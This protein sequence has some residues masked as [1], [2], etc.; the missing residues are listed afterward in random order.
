MDFFFLGVEPELALADGEHGPGL[1]EALANTD[2]VDEGS[3]RRAL[4]DQD[5]A[6]VL[7][8]DPAV[9]AR[10]RV[11]VED[12]VVIV[13]RPDADLLLVEGP[14]LRGVIDCLQ[15]AATEVQR[16][17]SIEVADLGRCNEV[18]KLLHEPGGIIAPNLAA[19]ESTGRDASR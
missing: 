7:L 10:H 1:E 6:G 14:L 4:I 8:D 15:H 11:I 18:R 5:V 12:D 3:V 17:T 2:L 9:V 16:R 19:C 13:H